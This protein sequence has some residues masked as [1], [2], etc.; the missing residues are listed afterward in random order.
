MSKA[1]N[2]YREFHGRNPRYAKTIT[3]PDTPRT[4]IRLGKAIAIEYECDKLHGGGDGKKAVYRHEFE[5][6][7]H[8]LI[9]PKGDNIIYITGS[10]L[11]TTQAGIEN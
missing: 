9:T 10:K 4:M 6:P 7:C 1:V 2:K 5:T 11:K 3:I 8:V